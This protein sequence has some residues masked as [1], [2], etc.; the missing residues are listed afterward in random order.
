MGAPSAQ[1]R[2]SAMC[3]PLWELELPHVTTYK[4]P[5]LPVIPN[6]PLY[7]TKYARN[8]D[9]PRSCALF[10]SSAL[11]VPF[12]VSPYPGPQPSG[13]RSAAFGAVPLLPSFWKSQCRT[14]TSK[15]SCMLYPL[16]GASSDPPVS[17]FSSQPQ[18]PP[19]PGRLPCLQGPD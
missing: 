1:A 19:L 12:C 15:P 10:N 8:T 11:E 13:S 17:S 16:L 7:V 5:S 4:H 6:T 9:I 18:L 3:S 14:L 2:S